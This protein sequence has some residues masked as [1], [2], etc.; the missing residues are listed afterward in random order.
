MIHLLVH[1][2]ELALFVVPSERH[3]CCYM[4]YQLQLLNRL[5]T[6][7][8]QFLDRQDQLREYQVVCRQTFRLRPVWPDRLDFGSHQTLLLQLALPRLKKPLDGRLAHSID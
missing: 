1:Q 8:A 5:I 7:F 6:R 4:P 3:R 2:P